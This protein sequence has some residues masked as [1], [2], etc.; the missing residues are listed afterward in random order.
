[1]FPQKSPALPPEEKMSV[2]ELTGFEAENEESEL[3]RQRILTCARRV[4]HGA[5][6][7]ESGEDGKVRV[8]VSGVAPG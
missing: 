8:C 4:R 7:E 3:H 6:I 2:A 5:F 1:M